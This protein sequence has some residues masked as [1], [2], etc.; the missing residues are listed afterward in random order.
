MTR[1]EQLIDAVVRITEL[2]GVGLLAAG[3]LVVLGRAGIEAIRRGVDIYERL[4]RDLGRVI[5]VGLEV[6]II[7]DIVR[8]ITVDPTPTTVLSLAAIVA[9]RTVFSFTLDVEIDGT[10]PWNRT[11]RRPTPTDSAPAALSP[12]PNTPDPGAQSR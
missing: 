3:G 2:A 12:H 11:D 6:L 9:I 10:W 4:R 1:N 7:A 8:T 5:L